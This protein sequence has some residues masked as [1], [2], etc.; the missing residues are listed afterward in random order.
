MKQNVSTKL[1]RVSKIFKKI[2]KIMLPGILLIPRKAIA[3]NSTEVL[4]SIEGKLG[5][6]EK[7]S[8]ANSKISPTSALACAGAGFC[9][10]KAK[11]SLVEGNRGKAIVFICG[12]AVSICGQRIGI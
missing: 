3:T 8:R 9:I 1:E 5:L 12:A 6:L 7:A 4:L 10:S 2:G 11:D